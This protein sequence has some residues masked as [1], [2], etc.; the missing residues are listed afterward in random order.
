MPDRWTATTWGRPLAVVITLRNCTDNE[1]L[2]L[3]VKAL[4]DTWRRRQSLT[5]DVRDDREGFCCRPLPDSDVHGCQ[6]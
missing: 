6:Y 2:C 3:R 1:S 4:G 5:E